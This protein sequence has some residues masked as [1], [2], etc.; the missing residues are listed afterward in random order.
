MSDHLL[1]ISSTVYRQFRLYAQFGVFKRDVYSVTPRVPLF[2]ASHSVYLELSPRCFYRGTLE[3]KRQRPEYDKLLIDPL[4]K[5]SGLYGAGGVR[6]DLAASLQV[7]T[8]G[9]PLALPVHTAYKHF[10]S[11]WK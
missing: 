9:R 5:Y 10:T 6:G 11:R 3:G 7:W 8:G 2:N 4:L 1:L